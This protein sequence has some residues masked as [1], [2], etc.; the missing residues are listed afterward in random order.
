MFPNCYHVNLIGN[1][2]QWLI[3]ERLVPFLWHICCDHLHL[4]VRKKKPLALWIYGR[5]SVFYFHSIKPVRIEFRNVTICFFF[6]QSK[7][8]LMEKKHY[9]MYR[10]VYRFV[11]FLIWKVGFHRLPFF[12]RIHTHANIELTYIQNYKILKT[13]LYPLNIWW[14]KNCNEINTTEHSARKLRPIAFGVFFS[15]LV[16]N[17][18]S[19]TA[20]C[21]I[22]M[23]TFSL[24]YHKKTT[25]ERMPNAS[26]F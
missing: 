11:E 10:S 17:I 14:R 16:Y 26:D 3:V 7:M 23:R 20:C 21:S 15:S 13:R 6:R 8:N 24:Y 4:A 2:S 5:I 22:D 19:R 25:C 18:R 9:T 1:K 12:S